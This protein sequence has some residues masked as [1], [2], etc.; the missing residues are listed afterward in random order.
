M[1]CAERGKYRG[2]L[3]PRAGRKC[4]NLHTYRPDD[5]GRGQERM[6][7]RIAD[8]RAIKSGFRCYLLPRLT[9]AMAAPNASAP[10]CA[11]DAAIKPSTTFSVIMGA[12]VDGRQLYLA[13][14]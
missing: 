14:P 5:G 3:F 9:A 1:L 4:A 6:V 2:F 8:F 12:A 7:H 10:S 13:Q 11:A